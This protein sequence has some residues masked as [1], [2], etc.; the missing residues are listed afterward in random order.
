MAKVARLVRRDAEEPGLKLAVAMKGVEVADDRQE[1]L[2]ANLLH[3]LAREVRSQLEN[4]S[5]G[6]SL[7]EI[8]QLVPRSCFA[9][10]AAR[11]QLSLGF[12]CGFDLSGRH[13]V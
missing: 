11:Q 6:G 9:P 10:P 1:N 7:V 13:G 5:P 4:K 8:K 12:H 2:L 3:V